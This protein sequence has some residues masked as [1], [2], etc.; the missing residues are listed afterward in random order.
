LHA[1]PIGQSAM[2]LQPQAPPV[3]ALPFGSVEQSV[4]LPPAAGP[5]KLGVFEAQKPAEVSQQPPLHAEW[6][7][8]PQKYSHTW[9]V[10][11]H[12]SP[13]GQSVAT[14]QPQVPLRHCVPFCALAQS[15]APEQPHLPE[16]QVAPEA[17][18]VQSPLTLQPHT[19]ELQLGPDWAS[20][21][22]LDVVQPQ[23]AFA[24]AMPIGFSVQSVQAP[25]A[26]PQTEAVVVVQ[27]PALQ[28][29]PL[30]ALWL[31]SPQAEPHTFATRSQALPAGQSLA[32]VQPQAP[33]PQ[34]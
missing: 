3:H 29:E 17:Q 23:A 26:G 9:R 14:L 20:P 2:R 33:L 4:Q 7:P 11:L 22:S 10:V 8:P 15:L 18:L 34:R 31:A 24:H 5:Q 30:Q 16:T 6:L 27:A 1:L 19:P 13:D 12:D 28:H 25:P 32:C 21:Q